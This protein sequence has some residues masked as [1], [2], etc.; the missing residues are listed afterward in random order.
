MAYSPGDLLLD[1]YR[2]EALLGAGAFGEVYRARH[3]RL[4][5]PRAV[6]LLR[7]DA[8]GVGRASCTRTRRSGWRQ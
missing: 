4:D 7:R 1:K 8:D 5:Q 2:L 3:L 6:K